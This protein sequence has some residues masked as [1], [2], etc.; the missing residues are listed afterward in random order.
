MST[1]AGRKAETVA[2]RWL[3]AQGHTLLV[4]N[5]RTRWC[6][7]D[8]ITSKRATIYFVEVKYRRSPS[9]GSGLDYITARKLSQMQFAAQYWLAAHAHSASEYRLAAIE[10]SGETFSVAAWLDDV[11]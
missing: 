5:W 2:A 1:E 3:Q 11:S 6:E 7:I 10:L 9:Y 8:I 4:Q